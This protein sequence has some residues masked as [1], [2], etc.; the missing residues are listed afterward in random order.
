MWLAKMNLIS[1]FTIFK[2]SKYQVCV[3]VK[4]PHKSHMAAEVIDLTPLEL[5][6]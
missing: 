3:Q 6:H 5:V 2:G 1:E 4:Q